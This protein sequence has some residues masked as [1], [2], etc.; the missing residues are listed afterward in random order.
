MTLDIIYLAWN[1]L[2]YTRASFETLL[3]NTNWEHVRRLIVYDDGSTD[4]TREYLDDAIQ[5]CPVEHGLSH[6]G[7]GSP[8]ATM[9]HYLD[10]TDADAFVKIDN[11]IA[12][13][14]GWLDAL[15]HVWYAHDE[16]ELLGME[17]GQTKIGGRDEEW[18][19]VYGYRPCT[20]I[21]GIGLMRV[22]AFTTRDRP[23]VKG[24]FGFTEWQHR[25]DPVRGWIE[26][27]LLV[28]QLDRIPADPWRSLSLAY[29][30]RGW[31]RTWPKM[32][33]QWAAPYFAWFLD[34]TNTGGRDPD[35][36]DEWQDAVDTA[37]LFML[38]DSAR[39]YGLVAGGPVVNADRCHDL[40]ARAAER[41]IYPSKETT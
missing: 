13:P 31:Q 16:L 23:R 30:E 34:E 20:H 24:R 14:P 22:S 32:D 21:G 7:F 9:N 11:D 15:L 35:G 37:H 29:I 36:D 10:G 3:E 40:I 33:E 17:A 19:G 2:D 39:Q 18:D 27:D 5:R 12:A 28:P 1:R 25:M 6:L 8:V 26:P 41:G 4:G 38:M